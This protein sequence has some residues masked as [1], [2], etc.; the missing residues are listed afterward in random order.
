[1]EGAGSGGD[2]RSAELQGRPVDLHRVFAGKT[3]GTYEQVDA[4]VA[5][6]CGAVVVRDVC[7][8]L[9]HALHDLGDV[10]L[11][12]AVDGNPERLAAAGRLGRLGRLGSVCGSD[13]RFA[14]YAAHVQAVAAQTSISMSATLA[15]SLAAPGAATSLAGPAPITTWL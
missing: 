10:D 6:G 11:H 8:D 7:A 5:H 9:A 3:P 14:V 13:H 4:C 12:L 15:P 1:M 2:A